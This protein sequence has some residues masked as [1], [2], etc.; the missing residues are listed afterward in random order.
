MSNSS[1]IVHDAMIIG[2]TCKAEENN[3]P[4]TS[5]QKYGV[6]LDV[7]ASVFGVT[8]DYATGG[9]LVKFSDG[10]NNVMSMVSLPTKDPRMAG[11]LWNNSGI[12]TISRG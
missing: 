11:Q 3:S 2:V 6:Y 10:N 8:G 1:N 12:M 5:T 9:A 4:R 7:D